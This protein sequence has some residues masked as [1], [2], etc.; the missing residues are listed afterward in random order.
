MF[1]EL[2]SGL[3]C[4]TDDFVSCVAD[5]EMSILVDEYE[6]DVG[7]C[8]SIYVHSLEIHFQR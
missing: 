4:L 8:P 5:V 3:A 2:R 1:V 6:P 7:K